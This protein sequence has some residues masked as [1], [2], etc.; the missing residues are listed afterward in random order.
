M[1]DRVLVVEVFDEGRMLK[2]QGVGRFDDIGILFTMPLSTFIMG[3]T[4]PHRCVHHQQR[5]CK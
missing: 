2:D 4:L 5:H 1:E 3:Q